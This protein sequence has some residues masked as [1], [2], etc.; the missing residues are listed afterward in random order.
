MPRGP[1][2]AETGASRAVSR[3]SPGS[4]SSSSSSPSPPE[5]CWR[6]RAWLAMELEGQRCPVCVGCTNPA[7]DLGDV[8]P[9]SDRL[10][11]PFP[12][13]EARQPLRG[14]EPLPVPRRAAGDT[15]RPPRMEEEG[16]RIPHAALC[17]WESLLQWYSDPSSKHTLH[18]AANGNHMA[19]RGLSPS[20]VTL[21]SCAGNPSAFGEAIRQRRAVPGWGP[22]WELGSEGS[23]GGPA[24]EGKGGKAAST[25]PGCGERHA[26]DAG[27]HRRDWG[28]SLRGHPRCFTLP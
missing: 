12:G 9:H 2:A 10:S 23:P 3:S 20:A 15:P 27:R 24:G 7:R 4:G 26:S 8:R 6:P 19:E 5:S 13:G 28:I 25:H 14:V 16:A 17:L 11:P 18:R 1:K 22:R 21:L